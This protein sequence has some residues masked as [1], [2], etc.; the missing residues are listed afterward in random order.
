V[1]AVPGRRVLRLP[2][3]TLFDVER[4]RGEPERI[5]LARRVTRPTLV[6]GSTQRGDLVDAGE[7]RSLGF[8]VVR[9]RGGGGAV[10]LGPGDTQVWVDA[11][12]PRRDPLW[13]SDVLVAPLW[14]GAWWVDALCGLG[15]GSPADYEVHTGRSVPGRHGDV[16]CFAGRGPGEVFQRG[17]KLVG[18]TQ[19]R[20][21]QGALFSCCAYVRW[22]PDPLVEL[23][24]PALGA[25]TSVAR[26]ALAG[27]GIGLAELA[28][29]LG[30]PALVED[31][32][33]AS[34]AGFGR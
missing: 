17:A 8:D 23:L 27:V 2:P 14:I 1:G 11:W 4:L 6:L 21:R 24:G 16:V 7:A 20:S 33:V 5:V 31:R 26:R 12:I 22:D 30:D 32:L 29:P 18:V 28:S 15:S 3:G 25:S 34:F 13:V 9:R 10:A 19:W